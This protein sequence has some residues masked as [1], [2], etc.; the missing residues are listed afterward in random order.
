MLA[1]LLIITLDF[2][3]YS[4][5]TFCIKSLK[6]VFSLFI[7]YIKKTGAS[8]P[9][10][11][12]F[13]RIIFSVCSKFC[14]SFK[15]LNKIDSSITLFYIRTNFLRTMRLIFVKKIRTNKEHFHARKFKNKKIKQ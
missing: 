3:Q 11:V 5:F 10:P 4:K 15:H 6:N 12:N 1:G 2:P 7:Q 14:F 9:S 8:L 13:D